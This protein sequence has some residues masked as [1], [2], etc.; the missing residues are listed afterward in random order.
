MQVT[1]M[2]PELKKYIPLVMQIQ[3]IISSFSSRMNV[4]DER[5]IFPSFVTVL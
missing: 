1:N 2:H 3:P 4:E 5:K